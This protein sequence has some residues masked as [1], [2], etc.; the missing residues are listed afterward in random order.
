MLNCAQKTPLILYNTSLVKN[1]LNLS[2]LQL[3]IFFCGLQVQLCKKSKCSKLSLK[4]FP[5][6]LRKKLYALV[7]IPLET[8]TNFNKTKI[9]NKYF[10]WS[11][12]AV[13]DGPRFNLGFK[14]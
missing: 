12:W 14:S 8:R 3:Y 4:T 6:F 13:V 7:C 9:L 1:F 10:A 11:T 2:H 5:H